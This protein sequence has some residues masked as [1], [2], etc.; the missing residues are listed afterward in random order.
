MK[1]ETIIKVL[2]RY[3]K[4]LMAMRAEAVLQEDYRDAERYNFD[5]DVMKEA[6]EIIKNRKE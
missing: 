1:D 6:I 5:A 3:H 2:T 4:G